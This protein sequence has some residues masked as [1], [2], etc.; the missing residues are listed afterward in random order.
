MLWPTAD[1]RTVPLLI[2]G[3]LFWKVYFFGVCCIGHG[4]KVSFHS[5]Y[6][7]FCFSKLG[8]LHLVWVL[9]WC[10]RPDVETSGRVTIFVA[11]PRI[12]RVHGAHMVSLVAS[13]CIQIIF[14]DV[15]AIE[16]SLVSLGL[17]VSNPCGQDWPLVKILGVLYWLGC[18]EVDFEWFAIHK[19]VVLFFM[20]FW[21]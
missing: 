6:A 7:R 2:E 10:E 21:V 17:W 9:G 15:E 3:D 5:C 12:D 11:T 4:F 16:P 19:G 8:W 18:Q 1:N 20:H 13:M 14:E